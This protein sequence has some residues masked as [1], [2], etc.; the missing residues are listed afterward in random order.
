[1]M[2]ITTL[3]RQLSI[4]NAWTNWV[5]HKEILLMTYTSLVVRLWYTL[6]LDGCSM[7]FNCIGGK[8]GFFRKV[9]CFKCANT[10][11]LLLL[12]LLLSCARA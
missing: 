2:H 12:L 7:I 5:V 4:A 8:F 11:I 9:V 6:I 1:M 3:N 10:L